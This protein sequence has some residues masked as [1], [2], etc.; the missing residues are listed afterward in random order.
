[1]G[2]KWRLLKNS[3]APMTIPTRTFYGQAA[4][5]RVS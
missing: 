1:L 3:G 4:D 2:Q 5:V